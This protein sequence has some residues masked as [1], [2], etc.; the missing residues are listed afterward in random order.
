[1]S[2]PS[3][4]YIKFL[5]VRAVA[6]HEEIDARKVNRVLGEYDLLNVSDF[7]YEDILHRI[8]VPKDIQFR[9]FEHER[10]V[11]YMKMQGI[12]E[13]W[14]PTPAQAEV[15]RILR[16]GMVADTVKILLMGRL[17][18][19]EISQLVAQKHDFDA[20]PVAI[21]TFASFFWNVSLTGYSEWELLLRGR[22]MR[23]HMLACLYGSKD[24]ARYRAGFNPKVEGKRSL[25][26]LHRTVHFR[27]EATRFMQDN[28]D[29]ANIVSK[30]SKELVSVHQAIYGEG[31]GLEDVLREFKAFMMK[32]R[33]PNIK[34]L[35]ELAPEGNYSGSGKARLKL[36]KGNDD[37]VNNADS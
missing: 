21:E 23:G 26:D 22:H 30:L 16:Q 9:D 37:D 34:P 6:R 18:S 12:Y 33:E 15:F 19:A 29:M 25:K 24:Q 7:E 3:T 20:T 1:M 14:N 36:T 13:I 32:T 31:A 11:E 35:R 17:P 4:Y 8:K 28:E 5:I 27:V 10:T 2:H